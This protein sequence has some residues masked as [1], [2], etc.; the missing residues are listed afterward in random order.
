M[1]PFPTTSPRSSFAS[2]PVMNTSFVRVVTTACE[3]T[4]LPLRVLVCSPFGSLMRTISMRSDA[5]LQGGDPCLDRRVRSEDLREAR[6]VRDAERLHRVGQ[7][8]GLQAAQA[9]QRGD[10]R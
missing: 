10:H 9:A 1:S 7:P 6:R 8:A 2:W 3:Y 5:G 4:G